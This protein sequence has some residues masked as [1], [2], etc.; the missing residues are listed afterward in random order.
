MTAAGVE[1]VRVRFALPVFKSTFS[2]FWL[3]PESMPLGHW[4]FGAYHPDFQGE[5][6]DPFTSGTEG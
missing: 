5:V 6:M 4:H 1:G 3:D 2:R